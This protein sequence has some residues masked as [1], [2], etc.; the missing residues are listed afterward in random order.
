M[1]VQPFQL[2]QGPPDGSHRQNGSRVPH[3]YRGG[4]GQQVPQE[5]PQRRGPQPLP[6]D[7]C[8]RS[9]PKGREFAKHQ[10]PGAQ[11]PAQKAGCVENGFAGI[12]G[13]KGLP[14]PVPKPAKFCLF[15]CLTPPQEKLWKPFSALSGLYLP[16]P[17]YPVTSGRGVPVALLG[18]TPFPTLCGEIPRPAA[19]AARKKLMT[20]HYGNLPFPAFPFDIFPLGSICSTLLTFTLY[21]FDIS[22]SGEYNKANIQKPTKREK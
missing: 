6:G 8:H 15:H 10:P 17:K 9:H 21:G 16:A 3:R 20:T 11:H 19:E 22:P 5:S 14:G 12:G 1:I 7:A 18:K 4:G 13:G 2:R